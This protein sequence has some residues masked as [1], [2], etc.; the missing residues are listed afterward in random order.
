LIK[1]NLTASG[2][3]KLTLS[4]PEAE[5]GFPDYSE[6]IMKA[7]WQPM[8]LKD[9]VQITD[10]TLCPRKKIFEIVSP[11]QQSQQTIVRTAAGSALHR[12]IQKKIKESDPERYEIEMPV[13]YNDFIYGSIDIY[14]KR[15]DTVIDIKEKVVN[16]SWEVKPFSSQEEQIK[17]LMAMK[18][19]SKGVLV[20]VLLN[21]KATIKQFRYFM[22]EEEQQVQL[23]KLKENASSYL[24]AKNSKD[25]MLANYAFFDKN[26][27]WLC[28]R[29]DRKIDEH[30]W[31][32]YYW[33]C[34]ALIVREK[35]NI[36]ND[37]R[38]GY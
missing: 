19:A 13:E 3:V 11:R 32:P 28:H 36:P 18:N 29:I 8:K 21:G 23:R 35:N 10:L 2:G 15:F 4:E 31:C 5:T 6:I 22:T 12:L 7:I 1:R 33:D 24:S 16:G 38:G 30:V 9:G 20:L 17:N 26:L 27:S 34:M 25:P 37:S 14:D